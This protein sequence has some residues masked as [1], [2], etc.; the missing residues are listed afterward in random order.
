MTTNKDDD[1]D[2]S[3]VDGTGD[4]RAVVPHRCDAGGA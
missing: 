4:S 2:L 1:D 3:R